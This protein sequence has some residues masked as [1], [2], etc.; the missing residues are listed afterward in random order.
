MS[1]V[2]TRN[3]KGDSSG[4]KRRTLPS[5]STASSASSCAPLDSEPASRLLPCVPVATAPPT[6]W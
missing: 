5:A 2:R 6:V 4:V 3:R 1:A